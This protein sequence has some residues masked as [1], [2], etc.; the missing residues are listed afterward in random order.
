MGGRRR[1]PDRQHLR[2]LQRGARALVVGNPGR[3]RVARDR[4]HRFH[5]THRQ[6]R[7]FR[8][9]V[10]ANIDP[11]TNAIAAGSLPVDAVLAANDFSTAEAPSFGWS[12]P[13]PPV[14]ESHT[15]SIEVHALDQMIELPSG[16]PGAD[17]VRAIDFATIASASVT[18]TVTGA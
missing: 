17:M 3:D 2:G 11:T 8:D 14:G 13:C 6:W 15:Y 1:D 16:T 10:A 12:G 5:R 7:G 9:L 4:R 18:G